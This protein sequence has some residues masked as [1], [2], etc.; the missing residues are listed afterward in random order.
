MLFLFC[1]LLFYFTIKTKRLKRSLDPRLYF[2]SAEHSFFTHG[3]GLGSPLT[4]TS[5]VTSPSPFPHLLPSLERHP[6]YIGHMTL[7]GDDCYNEE[8]VRILKNLMKQDIPSSNS[9]KS[10]VTTPDDCCKKSKMD[11]SDDCCK[12]ATKTHKMDSD[13]FCKM[14]KTHKMDGGK[15]HHHQ[16]TNKVHPCKIEVSHSPA[17]KPDLLSPPIESPKPTERASPCRN[18]KKNAV[19]PVQPSHHQ[20]NGLETRCS[21]CSAHMKDAVVGSKAG[22]V[23]ST[24]VVAPTVESFVSRNCS[25]AVPTFSMTNSDSRCSPASVNHSRV[26]AEHVENKHNNQKSPS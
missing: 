7:A 11:S 12:M 1:T 18:L 21:Q 2:S 23:V 13:D 8:E 3:I 5:H 6:A 10:K 24:A 4:P 14:A 9:R 20:N 26:S 19:A 25:P 15:G 17:L 16:P 22:S